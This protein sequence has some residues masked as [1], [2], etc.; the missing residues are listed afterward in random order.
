MVYDGGSTS[1]QKIGDKYGSESGENIGTLISSGTQ[2]T[3]TFHSDVSGQRDGLDLTVT[4][5]RDISSC[6]I[7]DIDDQPYTGSAIK[8]DLVITYEGTALVKDVDYEVTY[9]ANTIVGKATITITGKG[10]YAGTTSKTFTIV[11]A[12]PT[13]TAPIA[14]ADLIYTGGSLNLVAAG[15]TDFGALL[16]STDGN[17]YSEDIPTAT[18]AGTYTVYYKVAGDA[19]H[20]DV[21]GSIE[22]TITQK[23]V[24]NDGITVTIPSQTWT[25]SGLTPVITVKDGETELI[26][27][28][29]Y[30]VTAPS[31]TIQDA[32]DYTYTIS[33]VGNYSGE[34][35][36]TFTISPKAVTNDGITIAA[37]ADQTY[38]GSAIEPGVTVNDGEKNLT[39]GTDYTIGYSANVNVGTATATITGKG[40]YSGE[41]A[42]TFTII[43]KAVTNDGITIAAIDVQTYTGSAIEPEVTVNDGE[44]NLTLGTDYEVA[45]SNNISAGTAT[46]TITGQGNYKGETTA[47]FTIAQ[48]LVTNDGITI[49]IPSQTWTGSEISFDEKAVVVKDGEKTLEQATDYIVTAPTDKLQNT[50][51]YTVTINGAGNYAGSITA[52]FTIVP[53]VT[54]YGA[55]TTSEDQIGKIATI[56]G[57]SIGTVEITDNPVVE[58]ITLN[59]KF[60]KDKASTIMLLFDYTC[61]KADGGVFYDFVDV[62]K[63]EQTKTN[64]WVA[65]MTKVD[66]LTANTPYLFM[67]DKDIDEIAF[68]LP[69]KVTLNT[70][71]GGEC[72][73]ADKGSNWTFRGTYS[74]MKWTSDTEDKDYTKERADEIGKVYGFAGVQKEKDGIDLGD[75]VKA[76]SGAKIR[77]MTCYLM[78]NDTPNNTRSMTRGTID[79]LPSSIV[80][81]LL[82][83][84]GPGNQGDDDNG[85]TTAIGTLDTETGEIDFSGWYDMSGH[86][87]SGKPTK[88]GMY[89][90]N[91]KK[92]VIK[93]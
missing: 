67:P 82:S 54:T 92:V 21:S 35:A 5:K 74:Y 70:S 27:N 76:A 3:L 14:V 1:A 42:A 10:N 91:G 6:V 51:D 75:F 36:A 78:W 33:G 40:N 81:R 61:D 87:L 38:T 18:N 65:T 31:G 45:Y 13:V 2:M 55:L 41:K 48:K 23:A 49:T 39:L 26:K 32:G 4:L 53:K 46:V 37:I 62:K 57:T 93:N 84:V 63:D 88:K 7:A 20:N 83:N 34:K 11:K 79:E 86:K 22:V 28:T 80:V 66:K 71:K 68:T 19:N 56:D 44:K 58:A 50:G 77:P 89:I 69:E 64:Q 16:Y 24:T 72:Q 90:N 8:P 47:I 52:K 15:T 9:S 12:T 25:G 30:T 17:N 60:S 59:R 43:P 29:D 73:K 85:Q